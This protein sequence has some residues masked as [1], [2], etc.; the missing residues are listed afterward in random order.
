MKKIVITFLCTT[1]LAFVGYALVPVL[2]GESQ[3]SM[4]A[5]KRIDL[6]AWSILLGLSFF[7]YALR[8]YRWVYLVKLASGVTIPLGKHFLIYLSGFGLTATPGKIGEAF[9]GVYMK[10]LGVNWTQSFSLFFVER[11]HDVLAIVILSLFAVTYFDSGVLIVVLFTLAILFSLPIIHSQKL[12]VIL[13]NIANK[14]NGK[15]SALILNLVKMLSVSAPL[16][17]NKPLYIGAILGLISWGA[18]GVGLFLLL[19]WLGMDVSVALGVSIYAISMLA[20]AASFVPGGL[21]GAELAMISLLVLLGADSPTAYAAT[22]ICRVATLWFAVLLGLLAF[23][24]LT[25]MGITPD[26]SQIEKQKE[27]LDENH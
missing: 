17:K 12:R 26:F 2:M 23:L 16:L 18:E 25:L 10:P 8:F 13:T 7:N 20:G 27:A 9:R 4:L 21:V 15:I 5:L 14:N 1:V 11:L 19:H 22:V 6:S 24:A 3:E